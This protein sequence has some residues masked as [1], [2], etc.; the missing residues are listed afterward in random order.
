MNQYILRFDIP[1]NNSVPVRMLQRAQNT[2]RNLSCKCRAQLP[3]LLNNCFQRFPLNIFH[4][5]IAV[6]TIHTHIKQVDNIMVSHF[7]GGLCFALKTADKFTVFVI[8]RTQYFYCNVM[9]CPQIHSAINNCHSA[10]SNLF[11]QPVTVCK[12]F[13]LH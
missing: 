6:L 4:Y 7:A 10:D 8:F 13:F 1:V 2:D 12:D 9:T 5:K 3:S 11:R